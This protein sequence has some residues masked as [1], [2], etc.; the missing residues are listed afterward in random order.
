MVLVL[1][2]F[3]HVQEVGCNKSAVIIGW[4]EWC[5]LSVQSLCSLKITKIVP[6]PPNFFFSLQSGVSE[7]ELGS[8]QEVHQRSHQQSK[9]VQHRQHHPGAAAGEHRPRQVIGL[10]PICWL[11]RIL[12]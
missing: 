5:T 3:L 12:M 8:P 9:R 2:L 4:D 11:A 6:P 1:K 7:D 10:H